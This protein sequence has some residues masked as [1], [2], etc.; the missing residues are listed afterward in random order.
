M[1]TAAVLVAAAA[2]CFAAADEVLRAG[3]KNDAIR[4]RLEACLPAAGAMACYE[5]TLWAAS[6]FASKRGGVSFERALRGYPAPFEGLIEAVYT[7]DKDEEAFR[8]DW[9]V[10]CVGRLP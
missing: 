4:A 7:S 9:F 6:F 2:Q 5:E 10:D 1:K 8:R 3:G